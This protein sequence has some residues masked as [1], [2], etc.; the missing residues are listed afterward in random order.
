MVGRV[1]SQ[2]FTATAVRPSNG[3]RPS[4]EL[5]LNFPDYRLGMIDPTQ[6]PVDLLPI[7]VY[8]ATATYAQGDFVVNAG[9]LLQARTALAPKAF[10]ITDWNQF[11]PISQTDTRYLALT[12]GTLTGD[13][14]VRSR[15]L[16]LISGASDAFLTLDHN[17]NAGY[18]N[19]IMGRTGGLTRWMLIL[20]NSDPESGSNAGSNVVLN[21]FSDTG[22]YIGTVLTINRATGIV[23]FGA[24][25][26]MAGGAL[27]YLPIAG[28]NLTGALGVGGNGIAYPSLGS[29]WASNHVAVGWDG[30]NPEFA[31]N[32]AGQGA[33]ALQSWTTGNFLSINGGTIHG[34]L[35]FGNLGANAHAMEFG[36]DGTQI[37][38]WVDG[39]YIGGLATEAYVGNYLPLSGGVTSGTVR[40]GNGRLMSSNNGGSPS[41]TAWDVSGGYATGFWTS[42]NHQM[43]FGG[44]DGN[45]NPSVEWGFFD[46]SGN[47]GVVGDNLT[48]G[49]GAI[50]LVA[51]NPNY[52]LKFPGGSNLVY[53]SSPGNLVWYNGAGTPLFFCDSGG[54][55]HAHQDVDAGSNVNAGNAVFAQGG[56]FALAGDMGMYA[57]GSGRVIQFASNWYLDWNSGNGDLRWMQGGSGS[58]FEFRVSD[59][60]SGNDRGA[61]YG[62]GAYINLSDERAKTD[63]QL[64]PYGLPEILQLNPIAFERTNV[65]SIRREHGFSAQQVQPIIPE[66]VIGVTQDADPL[67]G[68]SLDPIVAALVNATKDLHQRLRVL[69]GD[70]HT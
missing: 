8:A 53:Q 18:N 45:G 1:Q 41:V 13:L 67:L 39:T 52:A 20:T 69:E 36:W 46:G 30:T 29:Y 50:S 12:G 63:I 32:G 31:V 55:L 10:A 43:Q 28:G 65:V 47:F 24:A 4:G 38:A 44:M 26:T 34:R 40:V 21:R 59:G 56:C 16:Y 57:G 48:V 23:D 58:V 3:V 25:P 22:A 49:N 62:F 19:V 6:A 5:W 64:S 61:V 2:R 27:P 60:H 66:A 42:A 70:H 9:Q 54:S 35:T 17:A 33:L 51:A 11:Q 15:N 7:R 68:V 14:T 37:L